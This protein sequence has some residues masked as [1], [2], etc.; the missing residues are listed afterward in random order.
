VSQSNFGTTSHTTTSRDTL[1]PQVK[2]FRWGRLKIPILAKELCDVGFCWLW[3]D[4]AGA[5]QVIGS[6]QV[7]ASSCAAVSCN[8]SACV[9]SV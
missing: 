6:M 4:C 3:L 8:M 5:L 2:V 1:G 9:A 7:I